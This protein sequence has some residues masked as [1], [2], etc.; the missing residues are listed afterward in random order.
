MFTFKIQVKSVSQFQALQRKEIWFVGE[1]TD[2]F[3]YQSSRGWNRVGLGR[4]PRMSSS[5]K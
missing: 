2:S 4:V 1:K 3:R 5:S